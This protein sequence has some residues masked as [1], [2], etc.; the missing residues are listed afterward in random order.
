MMMMYAGTP[1]P[2]AGDQFP[3]IIQLHTSLYDC[4]CGLGWIND[5]I[6]IARGRDYCKLI[7]VEAGS[8]ASL[9]V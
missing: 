2:A 1:T 3:A 8:R 5:V 6:Q 4:K 9:Y 7:P